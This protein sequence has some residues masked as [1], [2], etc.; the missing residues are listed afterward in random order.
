M[1]PLSADGRRQ[2]GALTSRL[3][4]GP[5]GSVLSS[6]YVRCVETVE[7]LTARDGHDVILSDKLA[8]GGGLDA[9][10]DPL[11]DVPER[12]ILCTTVTW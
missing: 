8:E 5:Q 1:R 4:P 9:L 7:W 3:Q 2:V 6:A 10:L 12:S 11:V